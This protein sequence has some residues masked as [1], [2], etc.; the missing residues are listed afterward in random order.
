MIDHLYLS[1]AAH[2]ASIKDGDDN[3]VFNHIG[4]WNRQVEF[5]EMEAP[6]QTPA[7][8]IQ[9]HPFRWKQ[10][11]QGIQEAELE[12]TLHL[13]SASKATP[14]HGSSFATGALARF[15]HMST[16]HRDMVAFVGNGEGWMAG[17]P[18]RIATDIDHDFGELTDD[19]QTY[20]IPVSDAGT[21]LWVNWETVIVD[22]VGVGR[23]K[24]P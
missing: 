10:L 14:Q 11:G 12:M 18:E 15:A 23:F 5:V 22:P 7:V 16:L 19:R 20:R 9:F 17:T 8:F 6:I 4:L 13:V 2:I 24:K 1:L 21:S 3:T